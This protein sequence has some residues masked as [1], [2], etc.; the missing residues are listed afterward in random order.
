MSTREDFDATTRQAWDTAKPAAQD[1]R[2]T[3]RHQVELHRVLTAEAR[4]TLPP[5]WQAWVEQEPEL[6][7]R[8]TLAALILLN[9]AALLV[10]LVVGRI[11]WQGISTVVGL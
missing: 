7:P 9:T 3:A 1:D 6:S 11:V 4:P 2:W 5:N 10:L 8:H